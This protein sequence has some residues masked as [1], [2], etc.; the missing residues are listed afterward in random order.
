MVK[1]TG[2]AGVLCGRG[3]WSHPWWM[4]EVEKLRHVHLSGVA[5]GQAGKIESR[6]DEF[7]HCRVI[8]DRMRYK[9]L[10]RKRRDHDQWHAIAGM[11][12]VAGRASGR[13]ADISQLQ[14]GRQDRVWRNC[15]LRRYVVKQ[16]T[17]FVKEKK[18]SSIF[19]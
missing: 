19:P 16:S 18:E 4:R 5:L 8:R 13:R 14:I 7:E 6:L 1:V 17:E 12:E 11:T 3:G 15:G 9:I 2:A 10:S